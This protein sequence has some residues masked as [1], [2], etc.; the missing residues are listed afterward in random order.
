MELEDVF[1]YEYM[2]G[3][4]FRK[5]GFAK[6]NPKTGEKGEKAPCL[7]GDEAIRF[8]FAAIKNKLAE[9]QLTKETNRLE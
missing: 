8:L 3:G 9:E 1:P 7:H 4:Y 5:K 2:G 6:G